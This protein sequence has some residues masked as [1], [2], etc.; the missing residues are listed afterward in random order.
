MTTL[1]E[2]IEWI[3][4]RKA[5]LGDKLLPMPANSGVA[6]T[7]SKRALLASLEELARSTGRSLPFKAN[8]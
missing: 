4:R 3:E 5:E 8:Y 7:E 2:Q 1:E 6:R